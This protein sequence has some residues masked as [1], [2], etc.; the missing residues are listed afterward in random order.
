MIDINQ[1]LNTISSHNDAKRIIKLPFG[2]MGYV[3]NE[4]FQR[5]QSDHLK[6]QGMPEMSPS[7]EL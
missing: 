6:T 3:R 5:V 2:D 4:S 7:K 1:L